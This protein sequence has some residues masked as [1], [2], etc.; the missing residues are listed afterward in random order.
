MTYLEPLLPLFLVLCFV[1]L[2]KSRRKSREH[3]PGR[4]LLLI[5]IIGLFAISWPPLEWLYAFPLERGYKPGL[6]GDA[7]AIVVLAGAA[8]EPGTY[9]TFG[10]AGEDTYRRCLWAA[11]LFKN[12][13]QAPVLVSGT[14]SPVMRHVL[15]SEGVPSS[16]IWAEA[17]SHNTHENA[18]YTT[19]I[20]RAHAID[21]IVLVLDAR[22][23]PR[24]EACFR[25]LGIAVAPFACRFHQFRVGMDEWLPSGKAISENS[26]TLHELLGLAWYKARG[27][28]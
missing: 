5:G 23:L 2:Y 21:S 20:L 16:M 19:A 1:G 25:K 4:R 6:T 28:I 18:A 11:W 9:R 8:D 26:A 27:W 7:Q 14:I 10:I 17:G 12:W 22:D 13:R 24:A 15:E 3:N